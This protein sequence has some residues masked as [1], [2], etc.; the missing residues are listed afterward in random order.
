MIS[1]GVR[2]STRHSNTPGHRSPEATSPCRSPWRSV[3]ATGSS[4]G[5]HAAAR[6]F[7][8]TP[9]GPNREAGVTSRC[10]SIQPA[11]RGSSWRAHRALAIGNERLELLLAGGRRQGSLGVV[12]SRR[13]RRRINPRRTAN[14]RECRQCSN[15]AI[16]VTTRPTRW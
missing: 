15:A 2:H 4:P 10:G 16:T 8:P 6:P 9:G 7:R 11:F 1:R 3:T 12:Q 13:I 14:G 5:G